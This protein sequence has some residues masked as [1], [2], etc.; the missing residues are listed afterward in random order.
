MVTQELKDK[1]KDTDRA[2]YYGGAT[3]VQL[4][5]ILAD[6]TFCLGIYRVIILRP[7]QYDE[8][9]LNKN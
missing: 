6:V 7:S 5:T 3:A 1:V 2:F 8:Q 4:S 9:D